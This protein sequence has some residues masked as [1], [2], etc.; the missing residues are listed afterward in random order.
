MEHTL[1]VGGDIMAY[2]MIDVSGLS[3]VSLNELSHY[4]ELGLLTP[5]FRGLDEDM[6]YE[7]GSC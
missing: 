6:Y 3:G 2:S 4:A 5:A 1:E 7:K